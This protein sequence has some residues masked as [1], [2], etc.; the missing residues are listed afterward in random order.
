M[1]NFPNPD[2]RRGGVPLLAFVILAWVVI[3]VLAS[4]FITLPRQVVPADSVT[5]K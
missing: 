5:R 1:N 2:E 3:V 4:T